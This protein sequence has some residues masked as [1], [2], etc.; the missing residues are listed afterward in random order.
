M[1]LQAK[2]LSQY[3]KI[4]PHYTLREISSQTDIQLTRLF[5]LFNGA[6]MKLE[7]YEIFLTVTGVQR[8]SELQSKFHKALNSFSE[9]E[10][11]R[12][13]QFISKAMKWNEIMTQ[14]NSVLNNGQHSA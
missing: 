4:Y 3:R 10:L 2:I 8:E 1:S 12:L 6:P 14:S 13:D 5:R 7:E 9:K 11:T